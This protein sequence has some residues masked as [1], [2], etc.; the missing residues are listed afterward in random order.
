MKILRRIWEGSPERDI[1]GLKDSV[2]FIL[3]L[4]LFVWLWGS[5]LHWAGYTL[6]LLFVVALFGLIS[7]WIAK[8][9][10]DEN[11]WHL[12][13]GLVFFAFILIAG[14]AELIRRIIR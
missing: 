1:A 13:L 10:G 3:F 11:A 6:V 14:S 4:A 7:W 8:K 5:I 12:V 2:G 9:L